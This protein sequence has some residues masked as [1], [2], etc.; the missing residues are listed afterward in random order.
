MLCTRTILWSPH[1][2]LFEEGK[3]EKKELVREL[4]EAGVQLSPYGS[5]TTMCTKLV[6][7]NIYAVR[8]RQFLKGVHSNRFP[9][10]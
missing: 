8:T 2:D 5:N 6:E 1:G 4:K 10:Y 9:Y 7:G 3:G